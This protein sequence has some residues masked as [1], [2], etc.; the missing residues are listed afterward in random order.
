MFTS[1]EAAA[2]LGVGFEKIIAWWRWDRS[3][4]QNCQKSSFPDRLSLRSSV[5][6]AVNKI[7]LI[8]IPWD[9]NSSFM[10]GPAEAPPLIREALFSEASG[11]RSEDGRE[12]GAADYID[13]GDL[14]QLSG[15]EMVRTIEDS[16]DS[17]LERALRPI[18]LGGDH[19]ITYPIL[20]AVARR[21][22]NLTILQFDAHPDLYDNFQGN[23]YSHASPFARIMENGL[24]ARLVQVG[25][26]TGNLHQREQAQRFG[27]EMIE[28]KD[29]GSGPVLEFDS[30]VYV[31]F[32]IDGLDP[33]FAP[34]VSHHEPG[35]LSTRQA[36]DV[37]QALKADVIGAD[38][39]EFNPRRDQSQIT[40]AVCAKLVKEI[41]AKMILGIQVS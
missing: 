24:A 28:M 33:A 30:P 20:R 38:I 37:L 4:E 31:S 35:G 32:D 29:W 21:Y 9:E 10:R 17:L 3:C 16:I 41:A 12:F 13:A 15:M 11:F 6:L 14:P 39:V 40:A 36:I 27:V 5:T 2:L 8:G 19:S 34:G 22:P 23:P 26:R 18:S 7:A 25:I 1:E